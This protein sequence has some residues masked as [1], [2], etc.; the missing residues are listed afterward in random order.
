MQAM[1]VEILEFTATPHHHNEGFT[2]VQTS[3]QVKP[4]EV[5]SEVAEQAATVLPTEIDNIQA[6]EPPVSKKQAVCLYPHNASV[7]FTATD[8]QN[9]SLMDY[10]GLIFDKLKTECSALADALANDALSEVLYWDRFCFGLGELLQ[11]SRIFMQLVKEPCFKDFTYSFFMTAYVKSKSHKTEFNYNSRG[12]ALLTLL[13]QQSFPTDR[14]VLEKS[15]GNRRHDRILQLNFVSGARFELNFSYGMGFY[16][17]VL[18]VLDDQIGLINNEKDSAKRKATLGALFVDLQ[19]EY[20][21]LCV[22]ARSASM[23]IGVSGFSAYPLDK[24]QD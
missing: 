3:V 23:T 10:E 16:D 12:D 2:T 15:N 18:P 5:S 9:L 19:A 7:R 17:V 6:Q 21:P 11:L 24:K 1:P 8:A 4:A 22:Q 20:R 13:K 14:L